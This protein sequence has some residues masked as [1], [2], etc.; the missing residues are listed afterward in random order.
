L[1]LVLEVLR[2][3]L[4]EQTRSLLTLVTR[5]KFDANKIGLRSFR[6]DASNINPEDIDNRSSHPILVGGHGGP[7]DAAP[8]LQMPAPIVLPPGA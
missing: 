5:N 1:R 6:L 4:H 7:V 2:T 8:R 3:W